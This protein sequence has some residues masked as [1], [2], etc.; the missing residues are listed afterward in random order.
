MDFETI[1]LLRLG[2]SFDLRSI[3]LKSPILLGEETNNNQ[4]SVSSLIKYCS[5]FITVPPY[6]QITDTM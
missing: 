1:G 6:A 4:F 2:F 5:G 3:I